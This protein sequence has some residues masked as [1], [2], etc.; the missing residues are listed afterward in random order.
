MTYRQVYPGGLDTDPGHHVRVG[1]NAKVLLVFGG[2]VLNL[3]QERVKDRD[4]VQGAVVVSSL[5][6]GGLVSGLAFTGALTLGDL[7]AVLL[8]LLVLPQVV[9]HRRYGGVTKHC[10]SNDEH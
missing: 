1:Q 8:G 4:P 6:D 7:L 9:N 3:I 10:A 2:T 5:L